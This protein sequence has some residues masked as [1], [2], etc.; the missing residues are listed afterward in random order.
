MFFGSKHTSLSIGWW[1][2]SVR[3]L[4]LIC[5][6]RFIRKN[7]QTNNQTKKKVPQEDHRYGL[8]GMIYSVCNKAFRFYQY[9][10]EEKALDITKSYK[11]TITHDHSEHN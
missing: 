8:V 5:L 6:S 4:S 3:G 11:E 10:F 7:K 9:S 1:V 2:K